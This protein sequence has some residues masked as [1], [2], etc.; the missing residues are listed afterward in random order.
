MTYKPDISLGTII[1]IIV[2]IL[3]VAGAVRRLGVLE[4]K[5]NI[6]YGWFESSVI[7]SNRGRDKQDDE[8]FFER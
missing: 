8:K 4:A 3:A 2:F 7:H 1:E 5:L 6:M